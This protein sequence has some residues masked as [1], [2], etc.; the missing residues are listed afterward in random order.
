MAK[1]GRPIS[2]DTTDPAILRRRQQTAARMR[3][4]YEQRRLARVADSQPPTQQQI[5]QAEA[6]VELPFEDHDAAQTLVALGLRVQNVVI[7]QDTADAQ[8]QQEAIE[9]NE[10][11]ILY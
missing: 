7:A 11:N 5:A 10:H 3:R 2:N 6:I 8:L 4:I 1:R 9:V